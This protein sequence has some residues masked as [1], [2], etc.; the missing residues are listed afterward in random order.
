MSQDLTWSFIS[1]PFISPLVSSIIHAPFIPELHLFL[2]RRLVPS[3]MN[4]IRHRALH[5]LGQNLLDL[6]RHNRV[7]AVVERVCLACR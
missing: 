7:L 4:E 5:A 1:C 2:R 3:V 6:L